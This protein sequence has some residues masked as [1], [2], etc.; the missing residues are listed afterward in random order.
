[1]DRRIFYAVFGTAAGVRSFMTIVQATSEVCRARLQDR[2]ATNARLRGYFGSAAYGM[3]ASDNR[4]VIAHAT[5]VGL[6]SLME[7]TDDELL[8]RWQNGDATSGQG[9]FDRYYGVIERFFLNKDSN[10]VQDLVQETFTRCVASRI[11]IKDGQFLPYLIGIA[12]NVLHAHL[13]KRYRRG[14]T[15]DVDQI[16]VCDV[17]PGPGSMMVQR[18]EHRLLLEGLRNIPIDDQVILELHYWENL[19]TDQIAEVFC[20]PAGTA[21][22][23]LQRARTKLEKV[24]HRL[25]ES[26]SELESTVARLEDWAKECRDNL[27]SYRPSVC[28]PPNPSDF[29]EQD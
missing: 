28:E 2:L 7:L 5:A 13:R 22:G 16:S 26:A 15:L 14:E 17:Q 10:A 9:L 18:R 21:K 8:E 12:K 3:T 29:S 23:R 27:D 20:I 24:I 1:M 4:H 11:R 19:T 25:A 6:A